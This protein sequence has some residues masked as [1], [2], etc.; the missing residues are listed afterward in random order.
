MSAASTRPE[1]RASSTVSTAGWGCIAVT[2]SMTFLRASVKE[3]MTGRVPSKT[4]Q[5]LLEPGCELGSRDDKACVAIGSGGNHADLDAELIGHEAQ[6][7][8]SSR[9]QA[10]WIGN[11]G[12]GCLPARE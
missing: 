9:R 4:L 8:G 12:R 11:S 7:V 10:R 1:A 6:I 2:I 3:S 5:R